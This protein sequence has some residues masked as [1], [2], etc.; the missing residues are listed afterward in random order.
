MLDSANGVSQAR[1][2]DVRLYVWRE[3]ELLDVTQSVE[4]ALPGLVDIAEQA[5]LPQDGGEVRFLLEVLICHFLQSSEVLPG[6]SVDADRPDEGADLLLH[7]ADIG[8]STGVI[9]RVIVQSR[10]LRHEV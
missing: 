3:V 4:P 2:Q 9:F 8:L 1:V 5:V 7:A 6:E 10:I